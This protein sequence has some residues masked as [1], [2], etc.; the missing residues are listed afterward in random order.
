[1]PEASRLVARVNG[2]RVAEVPIASSD[3]LKRINVTLRKGLLR[4]GQNTIGFDAVQRHRTDCSVAS[5]YELWTRI[6]G[7][8]TRLSFKNPGAHPFRLRSIDDLPA[9]GADESGVTT[10]VIV[11]PGASRAIAASS[12][13]AV[14]QALALRGRYGQVVVQVADQLPDRI[15]PGTLTVGLGTSEEMRRLFGTLPVE[16]IQEYARQYY[17]FESAFPR[18]LSAIHTKTEDP[19]VRQSLL[20][21]LWDEEHGEVN[22]AELWL[23]FAW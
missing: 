2:E 7:A 15:R 22:H 20:D 23:R 4:P 16:A 14:A 12:I 1:M 21:N 17:A 3:R 9:V 13:F 11:A 8:G 10:I 6:D 19:V 5:T 18:L